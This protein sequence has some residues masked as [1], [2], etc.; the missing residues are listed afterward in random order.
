[1]AKENRIGHAF[2]ESFN[3]VG[4]ASVTALS[5][6]LLN[7]MPLL[8]GLVVEAAYLLFV[9]DSKWFEARMAKKYDAEVEARRQKLKD[10]ILPTLRPDMMEKYNR[11][12]LMRSQINGQQVDD[13]KWFLEV[14]RKLDYLLE[15]F[16][17]FASKDMQFRN[18]VRSVRDEMNTGRPMPRQDTRGNNQRF[19]T[20]DKRANAKQNPPVTNYS[21]SVD[22]SDRWIQQATVEIVSH[23]DSEILELNEALAKEQDYDTK[24]VLEKRCDVLQRRREF[25]GKTTKILTNLNHQLELVQDT[26]GLINDEIRARSPEQILADIDDVVYQ[27]EA[28]TSLLE[29]VAPYEQMSARL[30]L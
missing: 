12:E 30:S 21:P 1:M 27:T 29:E 26:F 24:A 28:M 6:A 22:S 8:A 15:K 14:L 18:Y 13:A 20:R 25:V 19:E 11:L 4:L 9:P 17:L 5:V 16:L 10:Q 7:P 23:Y 2:R 3:T